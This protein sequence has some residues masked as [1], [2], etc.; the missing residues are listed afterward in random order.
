LQV[1]FDHVAHAGSVRL[2]AEVGQDPGS[3][4]LLPRTGVS[5]GFEVDDEVERSLLAASQ[6]GDGRGAK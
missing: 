2:R 1:V 4:R 6:F 5:A 3:A